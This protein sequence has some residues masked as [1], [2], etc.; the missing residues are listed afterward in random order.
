MGKYLS[1]SDLHEIILP[2][3]IKIA[4][5]INFYSESAINAFYS[6]YTP[7]IYERQ[8]GLN[9][10]WETELEPIEDGYTVRIT[11]SPAFFGASHNSD[12]AVFVGSFGVGYH[13]GPLAWGRPKDNIPQMQP[14]PWGLIA[15]FV[16]NYDL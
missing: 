3:A 1:D 7:R 8:G 5:D 13:G 14:S 9:H 4:Q 10:M 11:Y 12:E 16:E 2:Y 6:H 15:N